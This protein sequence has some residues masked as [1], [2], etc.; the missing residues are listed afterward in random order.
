MTE[1]LY[2]IGAIFF[3]VGYVIGGIL[4]ALFPWQ[5]SD[6]YKTVRAYLS[7]AMK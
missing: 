6:V 3:I 4:Y 1:I 5:I 7:R 2:I